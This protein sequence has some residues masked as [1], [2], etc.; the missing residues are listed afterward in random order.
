MKSNVFSPEIPEQKSKIIRRLVINFLSGKAPTAPKKNDSQDIKVTKICLRA[1]SEKKSTIFTGD[2]G[3]LTRIMMAICAT[4]NKKVILKMGE[5]MAKRPT[6]NLRENLKK[7]GAKMRSKGRSITFLPSKLQGTELK[8]DHATSSQ[9][10][11]ALLLAAPLL[12]GKTTMKKIG[13]LSE[14]YSTMTMNMLKEHGIQINQKN[15][16]IEIEGPQKY[17]E[18]HKSK[19]EAD[20]A[21]ASVFI[22][23]AILHRTKILIKNLERNTTQPERSFLA[24]IEKAGCRLTQQ[25]SNLL[26]DTKKFRKIS[27][28]DASNMPDS[29]LSLAI[30]AFVE[31]S[32]TK[33]LGTETWR[34]KESDRIKII[35]GIK[36]LKVKTRAESRGD[37]RIAMILAILKSKFPRIEI[38]NPD[39]VQKSY[40]NFW[41]EY[42][43]FILSLNKNFI[44]IGPPGAGKTTLGKAFA[45][46]IGYA[47]RDTDRLIE[48]RVKTPLSQYIAKNGWSAFREIEKEIVKTLPR[49]RT[50]IA[51]GGGTILDKKNQKILKENAYIISLLPP[52]TILQKRLKK[53]HPQYNNLKFI[54]DKRKKT[55]ESFCDIMLRDSNIHQLEKQFFHTAT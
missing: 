32:N 49:E 35:K 19:K 17:R 54:Y 51:T 26:I 39:C 44:L 30:L 2:C 10:F 55:Y 22:A 12:Q 45:K 4:M 25:G 13:K 7:M 36:R 27:E 6:Q 8:I 23:I 47:F 34:N 38:K 24:T 5:Q 46:K 16:L 14:T 52:Y 11:S 33:L 28:I 15:G 29:A 18:F 9:Y 42:R 43:K 31:K 53:T 48:K 1:L 40:S 41:H 50:V 37:H 21:S 20:I 3:L